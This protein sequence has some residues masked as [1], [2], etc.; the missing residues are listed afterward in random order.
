MQESVQEI[1]PYTVSRF[2][3]FLPVYYRFQF[4][5]NQKY[6]SLSPGYTSFNRPYMVIVKESTHDVTAYHG[7]VDG[8]IV[9]LKVVNYSDATKANTGL[10]VLTV[11]HIY[12][13]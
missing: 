7:T 2:S 10:L 1:S 6:N 3:I 11:V 9:S 12:T 4:P 8:C 5:I 13:L